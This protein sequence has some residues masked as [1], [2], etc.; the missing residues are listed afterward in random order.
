[1][2]LFFICGC[3][4]KANCFQFAVKWAEIFGWKFKSNLKVQASTPTTNT[5]RP[6]CKQNRFM[7]CHKFDCVNE[8]CEFGHV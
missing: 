7:S 6:K 4:D 1:M 3:T 5:G 2:I 8:N